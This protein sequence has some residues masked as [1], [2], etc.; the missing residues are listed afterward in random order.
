MIFVIELLYP[1]TWLTLKNSLVVFLAS[2]AASLTLAASETSMVS[3]ASKAFFPQKLPDFDDGTK[4]TNTGPFLRI[5]PSK[6]KI[7]TD[8]WQSFC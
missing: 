1:R 2:D 4:M 3:N 5:E 8:T 6:I 7:V